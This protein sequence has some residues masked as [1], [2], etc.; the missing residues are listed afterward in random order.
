MGEGEG[1]VEKL[2][3]IPLWIVDHPLTSLGLILLVTAFFALQIPR[4]EIDASAE[5]L[6]VEKDPARV[7]YEGIKKKFGSD[8]LSIV[9]IKAP[10]VFAP[11]VLGMIQRLSVALKTTTGVSRVE[12]LTT[13][14]NIK[15]EPDDVLNTDPLVPSQVPKS[16]KDLAKIK[17]DA[18]GN[19]IFLN[20][21]VSADGKVAAINAYTDPKPGDKAF[22]PSF[23]KRVDALIGKEKIE[24]VQVYQIGAPLIKVTLGE[25]IQGD[26]KLLIPLAVGFLLLILYVSFRTLQGCVIPMATGLVS[27][28]WVLGTMVLIGYPLNVITVIIPALM[29]AIGFTE[30]SHMILEYHHEREQG[31]A[32][33]DAIKKMSV[34]A[35]LPVLI[36]TF[37]TVVGFGSLVTS[38]ITMLIQ[39]G[40]ASAIGLTFNWIISAVV[41]PVILIYWPEPKKAM[42]VGSEDDPP[43]DNTMTRFLVW[44]GTFNVRFRWPIATATAILCV[45]SLWGWYNLNVNTDFVSFF[46][47]DTF[48]R[49]RVKDVHESMAG[50]IN[51]YVVVETG[52][53]DGAKEPETL[54]AVSGLQ[55]F[56]KTTGKVDNT[57]SLTNYLRT[58]HRESNQ[59]DPKFDII[60]DRRDMIA[61]Y[62]LTLEGPDLAKYVDHDYSTVNVLVRHNI[63][64]SAEL[65]DLLAQI[66][67]YVDKNFPKSVKVVFTGE[68]ILINNAADFMATNQVTGF[69]TTFLIIGIIHAV[70]FMSMKAGFISLLPNVVPILFNFGLMGFAGIPLNV[71]TSLIAA[72]ALGI[73]VDDTVHFMVRYSRELNAVHDQQEA[74]N[75]TVAA[76][77]RPVIYSSLA[78]AGGFGIIAFSNFIPTIYFGILSAVVMIVAMVG[79]LTVTP[80]LMVTTRL[81]TVWDTL[82][83][84]MNK[85]IVAT[86]PIFRNFWLWEAKKVAVMGRFQEYKRGENIVKRGDVGREM[87]LVVSG[88]ADVQVLNFDNT[89]K[90]IKVLEP[91]DI[92]G[93]MAIVEHLVRTADVVATE[94]V[95]V[96]S[97]GA[98]ALERLRQRFP[99]TAAKLFLNLAKIISARL[100]ETTETLRLHPR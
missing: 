94:D 77:G 28:I 47:E 76:M 56:L 55:E 73:A 71:G 21:I 89:L 72:I 3:R 31:L 99:Y 49:K 13:V 66:R 70:L 27:I 45:L 52:K 43:P 19:R 54:R 22:N 83:A 15:G 34:D 16:Q 59:S 38:D 6:M 10:D 58:M 91:G 48:I 44:L 20:N 7:Y 29:V 40:V 95:E 57:I 81:V 69:G 35:A 23:A 87:Y 97:L 62:L 79:E 30:D 12:S 90:T 88:K 37:T 75:R 9:V 80:I 4:L 86:T 14:N 92:F 96:L 84:K 74:T 64:S 25:Y 2:K 93:E 33:M 67:T 8:N 61:Q 51:F 50:V 82:L 41:V 39:F 11:E 36:T 53:E 24:G 78:L 5:G 32:K 100:R 1:C 60:P 46:K 26:M 68:G 18:L 85:D 42:H 17:S 98:D 63:T 65:S